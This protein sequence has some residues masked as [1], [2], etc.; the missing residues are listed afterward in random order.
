MAETKVPGGNLLAIGG[1]DGTIHLFRRNG[2]K[3]E[4]VKLAKSIELSAPAISLQLLWRRTDNRILLAIGAG[5]G[6]IYLVD[7]GSESDQ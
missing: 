7:A 4:Q 3:Y 5:D 6:R 2:T 1:M